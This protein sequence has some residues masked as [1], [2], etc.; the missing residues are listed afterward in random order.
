[1]SFVKPLTWVKVQ[2]CLGYK[3]CHLA[4]V[5]LFVTIAHNHSNDWT[6]EPRHGVPTQ[7]PL[8]HVGDLLSIMMSS[9][10]KSI[11]QLIKSKL[12]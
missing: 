9:T 3:R 11:K 5:T 2:T 1:M 12:I 7:T 10:Y 8:Q 4:L 6:A